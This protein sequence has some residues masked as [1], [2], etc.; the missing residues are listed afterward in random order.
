M[1][2]RLRHGDGR[3]WMGTFADHFPVHIKNDGPDS[4]IGMGAMGRR[5]FKRPAHVGGVVL[6]TQANT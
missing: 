5:E 1:K 3:T 2:G 6:T 4:G